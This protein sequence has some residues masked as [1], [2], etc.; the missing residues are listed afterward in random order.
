MNIVSKFDLGDTFY[1]VC[2]NVG[3]NTYEVKSRVVWKIEIYNNE[4]QVPVTGYRPT[5]VEG[6]LPDSI[7]ESECFTWSE[8]K[9]ELDTLNAG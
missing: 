5:G 9:A 2:L 3:T 7:P 8:A 6:T 1:G 4:S